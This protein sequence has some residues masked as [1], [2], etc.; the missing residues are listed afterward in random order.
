MP[1]NYTR[2]HHY[3]GS[4]GHCTRRGKPQIKSDISTINAKNT[5]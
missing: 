5:Q 2:I 3:R 1:Y 4:N